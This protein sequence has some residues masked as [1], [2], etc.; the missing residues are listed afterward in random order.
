MV[1]AKDY[2]EEYHGHK[3]CAASGFGLLL[4]A[5]VA[6]FVSCLM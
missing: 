1:P 3:V 5:Q 2:Y 6:V 4:V